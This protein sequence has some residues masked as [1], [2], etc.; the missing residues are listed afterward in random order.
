M[1]DTIARMNSRITFQKNTITADKYRNRIPVWS[2][3]FTCS[4]YAN[5]FAADETGNEVTSEE[6]T[7]TFHV[8]YCPELAVV[9]STGYR[10]AFNGEYYNIV[11]VDMMNYQC[12]EIRF[13]CRREK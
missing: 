4:A 9:T 5:T 7:V 11:S 8:R 12:R 2:D 1:A 13:K 3:Y 10:I 6:H